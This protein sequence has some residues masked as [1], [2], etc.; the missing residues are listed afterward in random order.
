MCVVCKQEK[1]VNVR[2]KTSDGGRGEM[3]GIIINIEANRGI[4]K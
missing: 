1:Y 3:G 4:N 2:I